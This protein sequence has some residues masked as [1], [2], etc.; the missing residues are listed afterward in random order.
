V[1]KALVHGDPC[2]KQSRLAIRGKLLKQDWVLGE[3][4]IAIHPQGL[5]D[6]RDQEDQSDPASLD[7]VLK[8]LGQPVSRALRNQHRRGALNANET[9]K[10]TLWRDVDIEL[11]IRSRYK[12]K[13]RITYELMHLVI[14]K[15]GYLAMNSRIWGGNDRS[16]LFDASDRIGTLHED[17]LIFD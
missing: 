4:G 2:A 13:R 11:T 15:A 3:D 8:T 12:Y 17:S 6:T 9:R 10:I 16:K 1:E 7:D 14:Q 5:L